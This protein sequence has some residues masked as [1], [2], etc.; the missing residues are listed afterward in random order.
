MIVGM[1]KFPQEVNVTPPPRILPVLTKLKAGYILWCQYHPKLPK[2]H[3]YSI[4]Q[5]VEILFVESVEAIALASF[6]SPAEKQ[7]HVRLA[8]R[9]IETIKILL[10]VLWETKSLGERR[11]VA[12][13]ILLDEV[14]KMLGGW[15]GQ[16]AKASS[17][18]AS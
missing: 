2:T 11:Y 16:L 3:R 9:K 1:N 17:A 12:L 10:M 14:G 18:K 7:P 5:R 6:L 15:N 4:G 8:I 13:S